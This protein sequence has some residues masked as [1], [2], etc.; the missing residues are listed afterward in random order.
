MMRNYSII[1][2]PAADGPISPHLRYIT[3]ELYCIPCPVSD[4]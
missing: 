1:G 4:L 3:P 2:S